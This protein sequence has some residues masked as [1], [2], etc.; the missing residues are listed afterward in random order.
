MA[1][2]QLPR[3]RLHVGHRLG[4]VVDP[5]QFIFGEASVEVEGFVEVLQDAPVVD[6]VAEVLAVVQAVD[7]RNGLQQGVALKPSRQ[8]EHG[9][10]RRVEAGEQLVHD[11][12]DL[13]LLGLLEGADELAVV[14]LLAAVLRHHL[15]PEGLDRVGGLFVDVG[16]ALAFVRPRDEHLAADRAELVEEALVEQGRG[17]VLGDELGLAGGMTPIVAEVLAHVPGDA[18]HLL[19]GPVQLVARREL[20]LQVPL[21][22]LGEAVRDALEPGVQSLGVNRLIDVPAFVEQGHHGLV[23]NGLLQGIGVDE[24]AEALDC[25]SVPLH[26]GCPGEANEAGFGQGLFHLGV[27]LAELAAVALVDEDEDLRMSVAHAGLADRQLELVDDRGDDPRLVVSKQLGQ[28]PAGLRLYGLDAAV[29]EGPVDLIVEIDPVRDQDDLE[30]PEAPFQGEGLG[31]HHHGKALAAALGVPDHAAQARAVRT[32]SPHPVEDLV[33]AEVLLV[34]GDL[35]LPAIEEGEAEDQLQEPVLSAQGVEGPVLRRHLPLQAAIALPLAGPGPAGRKDPV[36]LAL[37]EPYVDPVLQVRRI[38]LSGI[39]PPRRPELGC[40]AHGG[41]LGLVLGHGEEQLCVVEETGD[42]VLLLIADVLADGLT[43][44]VLHVRPLALD[45]DQGDPV[46]EK[47]DVGPA[48]LVAAAALDDE[49]LGHVED[50]VV[51]ALPIDVVELKAPGV[52]L[53]G[54][55][56][57]LPHAEEV[58]DLLVGRQ[59]AVLH[60]VLQGLHRS[61]DVAL[62]EGILAAPEADGIQLAEL[63]RQDLVEDDTAQPIAAG[64]GGFPRGEILVAQVLQEGHGGK[65]RDELL[66][67]GGSSHW[68][69]VRVRGV[70][71]RSDGLVAGPSGFIQAGR[72]VPVASA[73]RVSGAMSISSPQVRT[74]SSSLI[75]KLRKNSRS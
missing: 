12:D 40:G 16:L 2:P 71:S 63:V 37:A 27:Q 31:Q 48:R 55:R 50:V 25:T 8:V 73:Y 29:V 21:L 46:H 69:G 67:E 45:D 33:D 57:A 49:F 72:A 10:A 56:Q 1:L 22:L 9:V 15:L 64:L 47:H 26:H 18:H 28:V 5:F 6:D 62:A 44:G 52:P 36:E 13:R 60:D 54:L 39:L 3:F 14:L 68:A 38:A 66:L 24:A 11:D 51:G 59:K 7:A 32:G 65:L 17:L 23:P 74:P 42:L 43:D 58:I 35:L 19:L 34:A 75:E 53:D 61:Q 30:V 20:S 4:Q 41:V 70:A